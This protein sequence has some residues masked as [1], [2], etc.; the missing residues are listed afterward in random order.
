[1]KAAPMVEARPVQGHEEANRGTHYVRAD[2][3]PL[4]GSRVRLD[5][6]DCYETPSCRR[7]QQMARDK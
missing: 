6:R 4:C 5:G 1:M 7:C 2:G 3:R